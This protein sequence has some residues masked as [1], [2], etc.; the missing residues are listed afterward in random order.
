MKISRN[1]LNKLGGGGIESPGGG[2]SPVTT[3]WANRSTFLKILSSPPKKN[4]SLHLKC[5]PNSEAWRRHCVH[6]LALYI[7]PQ[8]AYCP[9]IR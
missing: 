5:P 9:I 2:E 6:W 4:M 1:Y 8:M 7:I 3:A